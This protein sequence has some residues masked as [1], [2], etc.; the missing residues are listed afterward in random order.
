MSDNSNDTPAQPLIIVRRR[1]NTEESHHGGV[2]KIAYADFMTAMMA[3]FL[4]MWLVNAADKK[5]IVQVAAYFNPMR[6]TDRTAAT[7]GLEDQTD[8]SKK[9]KKKKKKTY[10]ENIKEDAESEDKEV[11]STPKQGKS[12]KISQTSS[13][14][15]VAEE[16]AAMMQEPQ[17]VL[18]KIVD[19]AKSR[20]RGQ[21]AASDGQ[22]REPFDL[23]AHGAPRTK[24]PSVA[25]PKLQTDV[26]QQKVGERSPQKE[27]AA[28]DQ[29]AEKT[30][31]A[32]AK[33]VESKH[34]S[35]ADE[36]QASAVAAGELANAVRRAASDILSVE[37]RN[38]E[39]KSVPEGILISLIDDARTGMF[40]VGSAK[41][42]ADTILILERIASAI[43]SKKGRILVRGHTDG[44]SY[45][46]G[47][48][49][50]WRLSTARAHMTLQMLVRGGLSEE[51]FA[52]VEGR[53]DKDLR[54]PA[55][56]EDAQNCRI[57]ILIKD[58]AP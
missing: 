41:P 40:E 49:D 21:Q 58:Q 4:V 19:E 44:R 5:T 9:E 38:I 48:Y 27:N 51:R 29:P 15:E 12:K 17:K 53:A 42:S 45:K 46:G 2:W 1:R 47:S 28:A 39:V 16:E 36:K 54:N 18:Q 52:G 22:L 3:F 7:A 43:Q 23:S 20:R 34:D 57:D 31:N 14:N 33:A 26:S 30:K 37:S 50:N 11:A 56:K 13:A 8:Q 24:P 35:K 6:L 32:P 10:P 55:D 25:E